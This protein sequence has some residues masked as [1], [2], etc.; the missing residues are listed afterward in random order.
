MYQ[1]L[2]IL[3]IQEL[4]GGNY[5]IETV[6][7]VIKQITDWAIVVGISLAGFSAVICFIIYTMVDIEQKTRVRSRIVHTFVGLG[8]IIISISLVNIV[9]RLFS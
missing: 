7:N 4:E 9:I 5:T 2:N 8:G 1:L 3:A 6:L